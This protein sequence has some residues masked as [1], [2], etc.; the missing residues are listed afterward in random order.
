LIAMSANQYHTLPLAPLGRE[1]L[2]GRI[3]EVRMLVPH[4]ARKEGADER[5]RRSDGA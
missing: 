1:V 2:A 3:E 4:A 5:P